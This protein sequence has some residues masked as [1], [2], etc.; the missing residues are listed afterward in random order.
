MAMT[1]HESNLVIVGTFNIYIIRPDWLGKIGLLPEGS[2]VKFESQLNQPG[3]RLH[4]SALRSKWVVAPTRIALHTDD[5]NEDCGRTADRIL[6]ALPWTPL[7]AMGF[8]FVYRGAPNDIT[9]W[10]AKTAF[11]SQIPPQGFTVNQRSWHAG[12]KQGDQ[13]F[14]L[15]LAQVPEGIEARVNVH[16]ELQER[17]IAFAR[18]TASKFIEFRRISVSLLENVFQT[19]ID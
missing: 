4:S 7:M 3:F 2:E 6:E 1:F 13:Q 17:E 5:P 11:P 9:E 10:E 8:N 14:N 15:Q 19:R 16:T 18:T 12:L